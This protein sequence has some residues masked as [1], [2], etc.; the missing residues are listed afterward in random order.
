M[1]HLVLLIFLFSI[2]AIA[3]ADDSFE[4]LFNGKDLSGWAGK[5][6]FWSVENGVI[7]GQTTK[8]KP[9][10]GNTFLVWQGGDIEDF[11]FKAK[12]RFKGNN[13]GVQYRSE[14][15]DEKN[16]VVKGYQADL[17][18][19]PYYFGMLYAERWRGIVAQRFQKVEVGSDDKPKVVGEVGDRK[20]ELVD[21]EWN[22][23][24]IVAVGDRQIHQVNGITTIDLTD[25]HSEARRKGILAL[26]LHAGKPMTVEFK[27]IQLRKVSGDEAAKTLKAVI[28][29]STKESKTTEKTATT[30][31]TSPET[32][33]S[34]A[35]KAKK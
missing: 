35:K 22:E 9:T 16:F 17:H 30:E 25:N 18:K 10:K 20:Q 23:L 8:K 27:D 6:G 13:S 21:W 2:P 34:S 19:S 32:K 26:Q 12:V 28:D 29:D 33:S 7:H 15:V 1:K 14:L 24:T 31:K 4:N 3:S 5:A 11:V